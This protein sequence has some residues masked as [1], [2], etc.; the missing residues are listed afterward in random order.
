MSFDQP[1]EN[2][3]L[4]E[5]RAPAPLDRYRKPGAANTGQLLWEGRIPAY[6]G[7]KERASEGEQATMVEKDT[8]VVL[9]APVE[10][11]GVAAGDS[12]AAATALVEDRR[13]AT[14]LRRFRVDGVELAVAGTPGD[15]VLLELADGKEE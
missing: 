11:K 3:S 7:R 12:G 13:G 10:L 9:N 4:L 6:Y 15:H 1:W 5:L 2:C 8:L 14:V